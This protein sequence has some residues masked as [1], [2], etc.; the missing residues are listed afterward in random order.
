MTHPL[1]LEQLIDRADL[2]LDEPDLGYE[3]GGATT[4]FKC[5]DDDALLLGMQ[6]GFAGV[7][8]R[9]DLIASLGLT[10][11]LA[12][13]ADAFDKWLAGAW[14]RRFSAACEYRMEAAE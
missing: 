11:V 5:D 7:L 8:C 4:Y 12:M 9:R 10:R 1:T 3:W 2:T 6:L 14:E 13:E